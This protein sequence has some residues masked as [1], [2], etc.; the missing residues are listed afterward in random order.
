MFEETLQLIDQVS[1]PAKTMSQSVFS[2]SDA[3]TSLAK[4][5]ISG[6]TNALADMAKGLDNVVPGL[7]TLTSV[8]IRAAG[9]LGGLVYEGARFA[10]ESV[11]AK[12]QLV[13]TY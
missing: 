9:A 6:A 12:Q 3:V 2:L 10:L 13:A 1:G 8:A 5:D 7:G 4:G 11:A